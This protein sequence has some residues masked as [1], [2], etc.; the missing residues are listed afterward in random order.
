VAADAFKRRF[1]PVGGLLTQPRVGDKIGPAEFRELIET[2]VFLP[3]HPRDLLDTTR[4]TVPIFLAVPFDAPVGRSLYLLTGYE[5]RFSKTQRCQ[6]E[7]YTECRQDHP[8]NGTGDIQ[9]PG[10]PASTG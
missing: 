4:Y 6:Y 5:H 10:I 9:S 3:P 1:Q 7:S 2:A 8:D